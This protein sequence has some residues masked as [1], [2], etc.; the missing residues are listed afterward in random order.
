M[1]YPIHCIQR[2][3]K[4]LEVIQQSQVEHHCQQ[5]RHLTVSG[6]F[7]NHVRT[8]IIDCDACENDPNIL[9]L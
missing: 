4:I 5:Q 8:A 9:S 1:E 6:K 7:S 2:K 3:I